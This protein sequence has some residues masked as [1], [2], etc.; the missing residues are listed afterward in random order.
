[1]NKNF[2]VKVLNI[3]YVSKDIL[4]V[5]TQKPENYYFEPGGAVAI[6]INKPGWENKSR[7]FT[8]TNL[9][10]DNFLEFAIKIYPEGRGVTL[11]ISKLK[12]GD[13]L[14]IG[15]PLGTMKYETEGIFIAG[16]CGI[17]PFMA[18]FRDL[19]KHNKIGNN[20][21]FYSNKTEKDVIFKEEL[22]KMLGDNAHFFLTRE[23]I[24]GYHY[25]RIDKESIKKIVGTINK[26]VYVCGPSEMIKNMNVIFHE[27]KKDKIITEKRENC[28]LI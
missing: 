1:M 26:Q 13:E 15:M 2:I 18:I 20:I 3:G 16:G 10:S 17:A 28:E 5:R 22:Q 19:Y 21:L 27:L 6:S 8:F 14:I 23:K 11:E 9:N 12:K 24:E 25:G 7:M 4:L